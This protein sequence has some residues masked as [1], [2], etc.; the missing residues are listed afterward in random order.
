MAE[1]TVIRTPDQRVRVFVS[2]TLQE[3]APEREA[4]R[5]AVARLRLVPVMFEL[6]AR[7]H[8]PRRVYRDYL[9]QSQIFI[10]VYWQSY[11]WVAPDAATSGLEDEYL[12]SAGLPRLVYV[13]APAPHREPRL[14]EMLAR[15]ENSAGVSYRQFSDAAELQNLV[16]NDLAVLLSERFETGWPRELAGTESTTTDEGAVVDLALP[17]LATPLIGREQEAR[18]VEDLV[19]QEGA[20]LVTFTGPGGIGK[21]RLAVDVARWLEPQFDDGGASRTSVRCG[22]PGWQTRSRRRCR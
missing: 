2:S 12:L 14:E 6:G 13:K 5:A 10:G 8:P 16:E 19:M 9:A 22:P 17:V 18:A 11:G 7:A 4:V 20:R 21:S 3:L 1:T 15:I